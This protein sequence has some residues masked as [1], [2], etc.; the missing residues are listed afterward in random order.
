MCPWLR[1]PRPALL[2]RHCWCWWSPVRFPPEV[3]FFNY[4]FLGWGGG[5]ARYGAV[6]RRNF[7]LTWG[8]AGGRG[9]KECGKKPRTNQPLVA[10][11]NRGLLRVGERFPLPYPH[12]TGRSVSLCKAK[13]SLF[14]APRSG[15]RCFSKPRQQKAGFLA[16]GG[17]GR[18]G[19]TPLCS[20]YG[21]FLREHCSTE[22]ARTAEP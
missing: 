2:E 1:F 9:S 7:T 15:S 6:W 17:G 19:R 12:P 3:F 5:G 16:G 18:R 22:A 10:L 21:L 4:Y 20:S 8:E 14:Q 13:P 11:S